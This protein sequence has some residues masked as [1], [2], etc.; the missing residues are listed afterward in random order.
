MTRAKSLLLL[1]A[2]PSLL[3]VACGGSPPPPSAPP[4][5]TA[6][7]VS[8]PP[9]TPAEP[10][11]PAAEAPAAPKGPPPAFQL[12]GF[13]TP[14][15]VFYD[16]A[17][18]RYLV[19]NING[20]PV[21]ADNNGYIS[22]VS[23]DGKMVTEKWIAGGQNKVTLNA[24]KGT[25]LAGG[26][27]YVAD[28]DTVRM[29]DAKSGAP[30]GELKV[31][32]ATFLNDVSAAPDGRVY[33]SDSGL[34][35]DF[36]PTGTDAIYAVDKGKLK[37]VAKDASLGKPNGLLATKDGLWVVTFGSGELYRLDPKALDGK[38]AKADVVKLP[39]GQLDGIVMNGDQ[40]F[41]S[42]WEGTCVFKGK[43][44]GP[45]E[46]AFPGLKAPADIGFDKKR[47]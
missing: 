13:Q 4:P 44:A 20:K 5:T 12:T 45:F 33:V 14:E 2:A 23:P 39:K 1:V 47:S 9:V 24:P 43:A 42:S 15:S 31:P 11:K 7:A 19:S 30:K 8:A 10:A 35:G 25:A 16:E 18:D 41:V 21:E 28:I 36:G 27:L 32:G 29:F 17:N 22:V 40:L 34:N 26:V 38:A 37:T 6:A 3:A 46:V